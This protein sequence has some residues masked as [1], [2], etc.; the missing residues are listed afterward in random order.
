MSDFLNTDTLVGA[1]QV[2]DPEYPAPLWRKE[3]GPPNPSANWTVMTTV[4]VQYRL[5]DGTNLTE[6]TQAEMDAVDLAEK[7]A[8]EDSSRLA[9]AEGVDGDNSALNWQTRAI[10]GDSNQRDNYLV[11]RIEELQDTLQAIKATTGPADD[12]RDAI[13]TTFSPTSTRDRR[14]AYTAYKA[15]IASGNAEPDPP[16][17]RGSGRA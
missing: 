10:I 14:T 16:A 7:D 12:I 17:G 9:A 13:P 1:F 5:W 4:P 11:N 8:Q 15:D 6:M 2:N 3:Q